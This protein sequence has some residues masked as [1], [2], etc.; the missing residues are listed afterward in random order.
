M[1]SSFGVLPISSLRSIRIGHIASH[2]RSAEM[3][4]PKSNF[5]K[6]D[7]AWIQKYRAA[8]NSVPIHHSKIDQLREIADQVRALLASKADHMQERWGSYNVVKTN[9]LAPAQTAA[10]PQLTTPSPKVARHSCQVL[11]GQRKLMSGGTNPNGLA[12]H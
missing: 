1:I 3:E 11:L 7:E 2:R 6:S 12:L 5:S 10:S 9:R 4:T 8:L